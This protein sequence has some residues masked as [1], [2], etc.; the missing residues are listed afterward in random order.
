MSYRRG[1]SDEY[2]DRISNTLDATKALLDDPALPEVASLV[3][4]LNKIEPGGIGIGLK[5][6][7]PPLRLYVKTR[8]NPWLGYAIIAGIIG[9]P[10]LLG[11]LFGRK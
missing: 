3:I 7:V 8:E 6:V 1:Y 2:V 11:Y 4:K 10:F 5:R 9:G